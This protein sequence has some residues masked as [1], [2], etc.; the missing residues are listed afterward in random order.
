MK[1]K[2][3]PCCWPFVRGIHRSPVKSPYKG[4]WCGALMFSLISAWTNGWVKPRR[5]WFETPPS[6]LWR[7]CNDC[8][9][10]NLWSA[11]GSYGLWTF[12]VEIH[13]MH[14]G[15][16]IQYHNLN[17][18][19]LTPKSN[20][21]MSRVSRFRRCDTYGYICSFDMAEPIV[22]Y[23]RVYAFWFKNSDILHEISIWTEVNFD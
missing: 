19:Y 21:H 22:T 5:R 12:L 15:H 9:R 8:C 4:Q 13:A 16:F 20:I 18:T 7:H 23:W 17:I 10:R 1:W 2:H 14:L 11:S 6:P 3:L